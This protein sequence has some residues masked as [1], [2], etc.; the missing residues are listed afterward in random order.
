MKYFLILFTFICAN[1]Q[2]VTPDLKLQ[3]ATVYNQG[4][5]LK[6]IA[7]IKLSKGQ[8]S[9]VFEDLSPSIS[10]ESIMIKGLKDIDLNSINYE[11]DYLITDQTSRG[12][13]DLK[14]QLEEAQKNQSQ[15]QSKITAYQNELELLKNNQKLTGEQSDIS[16]A[17]VNT[18]A[19]FYR[20][21]IED[22][23]NLIFDLNIK[24]KEQQEEVQKV[25]NELHKLRGNQKQYRGKITLDLNVTKASLK[26]L[27][28]SYFVND[29]G[30]YP[31]YDLK[32]QDISS[33][34]E[35]TYKANVFQQTGADW[36][37]ID[38]SLSSAQPNRTETKPEL[39]PYYLNFN[40]TYRNSR[41]RFSHVTYNPSIKRVS[42]TVYDEAGRPLPGVNV[43][44]K[45]TSKGTQ[46]DF[47]GNYSIQVNN[48]KSLE[49]SYVGFKTE[50]IPIYASNISFQMIEDSAMLSEVVV[51]GYASAKRNDMVIEDIE[52]EEIVVEKNYTTTAVNFKIPQKVNLKSSRDAEQFELDKQSLETKYQYF[53]APELSSSVFLIAEVSDWEEIDLLT[54]EAQIYFDNTYVG[55]TSILPQN[56]DEKLTISLGSDQQITL[57]REQPEKMSSKSFFGG[58]RIVEKAYDIK[59]KNNKNRSISLLVQERLP[60]SQNDEIKVEDIKHDATF[61]DKD[62]GF[63]NWELTLDSQSQKTLKYSY[64]V[65]YPKGKSI[66]I[67]D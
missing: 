62:K 25:Q 26:N 19:N 23:N 61:Y 51:T 48:S 39:N 1:A 4:A 28:L 45:G 50:N 60:I 44:L 14:N 2:V 42:G 27:E 55:T 13:D 66:N 15:T 59:M 9:I 6:A 52:A 63:L 24:L 37:D 64:K 21:K 5:Q 8:H 32:S 36:S 58:T 12:I 47:D 29:A 56:I 22:I 17:K 54:G 41:N 49:F 31:S 18:Y 53:A 65:K 40:R 10:S 11:R 3:S 7:N 57:E 38:L 67:R 34:I 35:L 16:I 46:T 33:D 30:W 43:I 20:N